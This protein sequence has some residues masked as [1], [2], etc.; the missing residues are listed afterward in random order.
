[1]SNPMQTLLINSFVEFADYVNHTDLD[2][3]ITA[4]DTERALKLA[5]SMAVTEISSEALLPIFRT[6]YCKNREQYL[7]M[8]A[9]MEH[10]LKTYRSEKQKRDEQ[11]RQK[12]ELQRALSKSRQAQQK[13]RQRLADLQQGSSSHGEQDQ[14]YG[15]PQRLTRK[16]KKELSDFHFESDLLKKL[17]AGGGIPEDF[18]YSA[19]ISDAAR[20]ITRTAE[21]RLIDGTCTSS[22]L[23]CCQQLHTEL[24][25]IYKELCTA[26]E[27]HL[28]QHERDLLAMQNKIRK[29]EE[30]DRRIQEKID[31][32]AEKLKHRQ[33]I[34]SQSFYHRDA[35]VP[36]GVAV[37]NLRDNEAPACAEKDLTSLSSREKG[38]LYRYLKENILKFRTRLTRH[39]DQMDR[40][41]LDMAETIRN[42]CRSGGIPM[43]LH[44]RKPRPG[45]TNLFLI[46]DISGSCIEA[47]EMLLA[48]VYLLQD[49]FPRGCHTF[50]FVNSLYDL[51]GIMDVRIQ[52]INEAI[53]SVLQTIPSKGVYSNYGRPIRTLY[54][55]HLPEITKDSIIIWM[56]DA[57]NNNREPSY[58]EFRAICRRAKRAYFL[59]TEKT[60]L[61]NT[62]DSIAGGYARYAKMYETINVS[63]LAGFIRDGIR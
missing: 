9:V 35:F 26:E 62:A 59:N 58:R 30:E 39:I 50:A 4:P 25:K 60:A 47:S 27:T 40:A 44:Y 15:L 5:S 45:R 17:L 1:M 13:L 48:F 8:P 29:R 12:A 21:S 10:F 38:L 32:L 6:V 46:V 14:I 37:Q 41:C 52:D 36:H 28:T 56:G 31:E 7:A 3:H 18:L 24:T 2:F 43:E 34:K 22:Q 53:R 16:A 51:S 49:A 54:Q 63:E 42:A 33:I 20:E 61:W 55:K 11:E 57:R 19:A 23:K